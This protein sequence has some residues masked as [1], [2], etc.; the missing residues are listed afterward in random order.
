MKVD[1]KDILGEF[2]AILANPAIATDV[3]CKV[4]LHKELFVNE[5]AILTIFYFRKY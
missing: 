1:P 2:S 4:S 5:H 3:T